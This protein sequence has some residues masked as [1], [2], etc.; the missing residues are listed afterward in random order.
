MTYK[1]FFQSSSKCLG[2]KCFFI[3]WIS[4]TRL[5]SINIWNKVNSKK[6]YTPSLNERVQSDLPRRFS[7][8]WFWNP[9]QGTRDETLKTYLRTEA[10]CSLP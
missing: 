9:S 10:K 2:L 4:L 7:F 3:D 6:N 8:S 1:P 5:L